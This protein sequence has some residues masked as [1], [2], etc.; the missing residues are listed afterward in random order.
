MLI[1]FIETRSSTGNSPLL[2][3]LLELNFLNFIIV[4]DHMY[5][6]KWLKK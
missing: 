1:Y 3:L 2:Q 4:F 5:K 6:V